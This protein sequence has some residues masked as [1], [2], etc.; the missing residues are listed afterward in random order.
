M[1]TNNN[2]FRA[3]ESLPWTEDVIRAHRRLSAITIESPL[4]RKICALEATMS[5]LCELWQGAEIGKM[6]ASAYEELDTDK[7]NIENNGYIQ[8]AERLDW[9]FMFSFLS[10]LTCPVIYL[11]LYL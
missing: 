10:M 7:R 3:S 9:I 5:R 6:V 4:H 11:Y 2:G 1:A 8:I